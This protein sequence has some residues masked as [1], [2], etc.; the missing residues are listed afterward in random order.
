MRTL[1]H[2]SLD[3]TIKTCPLLSLRLPVVHKSGFLIVH[4]GFAVTQTLILFFHSSSAS[5]T[6]PATTYLYYPIYFSMFISRDL[7][8]EVIFLQALN[9]YNAWRALTFRLLIDSW[10]DICENGIVL[11]YFWCTLCRFLRQGVLHH[12]ENRYHYTYRVDGCKMSQAF[13]GD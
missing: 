13:D 9:V 7:N 8:R 11:V 10:R 1:F 6:K 5:P 3:Y 4:R 12:V 2:D